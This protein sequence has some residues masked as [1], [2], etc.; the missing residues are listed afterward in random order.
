MSVSLQKG[1]KIS[2]DKEAGGALRSHQGPDFCHKLY[3][4]YCISGDTDE[5]FIARYQ[6]NET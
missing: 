4:K 6:Q 1:Q 5:P 2:L 3:F